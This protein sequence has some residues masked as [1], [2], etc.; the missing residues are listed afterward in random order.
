MTRRS[1]RKRVIAPRERGMAP[2]ATP[3]H[4]RL[5]SSESIRSPR[6]GSSNSKKQG[7]K[8]SERETNYL[9]ELFNPFCLI[10]FCCNYRVAGAVE[11]GGGVVAAPPW[12]KSLELPEVL[13][14]RWLRA[15]PCTP[16]LPDWLVPVASVLL[17]LVPV[18]VE[19]PFAE[20]P[21]MEVF[22][23]ALSFVLGK[24]LA[25]VG[26]V[27][28]TAVPVALPGVPVAPVLPGSALG[29]PLVLPFVPLLVDPLFVA[30]P[31][32][33]VPLFADPWPAVAELPAEEPAPPVAA[34]P[35]PEVCAIATPANI[36]PAA[37]ITN[38]TEFIDMVFIRS[39]HR[40]KSSRHTGMA[41]FTK[42]VPNLHAFLA[43]YFNLT[44]SRKQREKLT[45]RSIFFSRISCFLTLR[46]I[47]RPCLQGAL[48]YTVVLRRSSERL[49]SW[50]HS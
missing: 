33:D 10:T 6:S 28:S 26:A 19:L 5:G 49:V 12:F 1:Y 40:G 29:D 4:T 22:P 7:L 30:E 3:R 37:N 48:A 45:L 34:P 16:L 43:A 39:P 17:P 44:W 14:L 21:D 25:V 11:A 24:G 38:R 46:Q 18:P 50:R 20:P 9:A 36:V 31:E 27:G 8:Q 15:L 41:S 35:A 13:P 23:V 47:V 42:W 2:L 32:P